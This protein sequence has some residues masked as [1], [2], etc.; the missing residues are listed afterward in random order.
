M[1]SK[2][3]IVMP[4]LKVIMVEIDIYAGAENIR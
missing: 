1:Q 2:F 3:N 4:V